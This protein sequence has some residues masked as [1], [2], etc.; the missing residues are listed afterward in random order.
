MDN[1][2]TASFEDSPIDCQCVLQRHLVNELPE[3]CE[4]TE[5]MSNLS[6]IVSIIANTV[7][8]E[9]WFHIFTSANIVSCAVLNCMNGGNASG[10][11]RLVDNNNSCKF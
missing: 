5:V 3:Q 7:E 4:P 9:I 10:S 11:T 1:K 6:N 2:L 8:K